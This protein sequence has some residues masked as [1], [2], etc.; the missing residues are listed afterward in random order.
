LIECLKARLLKEL[1]LRASLHARDDRFSKSVFESSNPAGILRMCRP[2]M[3]HA[4]APNFV[5]LSEN[6]DAGSELKL[7]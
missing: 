4:K 6:R 5:S 3:L 7:N 1:Q 2:L